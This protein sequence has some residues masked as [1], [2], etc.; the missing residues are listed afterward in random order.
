MPYSYP[1]YKKL[2][3]AHLVLVLYLVRPLHYPTNESTWLHQTICAS[4]YHLW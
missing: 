4:I 1:H 2:I 3:Y